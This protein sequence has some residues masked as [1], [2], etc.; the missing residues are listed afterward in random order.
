[1]R[2]GVYLGH[3]QAVKESLANADLLRSLPADELE[4]LGKRC[5]W[6]HYT[7]RQE[8]VAFQ[9]DHSFEKSRKALAALII[10]WVKSPGEGK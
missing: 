8:I 9:D 10:R 1:M 2:K 4:V 6:R 7:A 3:G 5:A